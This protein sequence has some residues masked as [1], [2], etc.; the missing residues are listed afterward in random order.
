VCRR[1]PSLGPDATHSPA[2]FNAPS[3]PAL[4]MDEKPLLLLSWHYT[5]D[6]SPVAG[7]WWTWTAS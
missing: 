7:A 4:K 1:C 6:L 2:E 3:P 5:P